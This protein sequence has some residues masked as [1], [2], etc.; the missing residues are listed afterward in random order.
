MKIIFAT[1]VLVALTFAE[2][3]NTNLTSSYEEFKEKFQKALVEVIKLEI[4]KYHAAH[5]NTKTFR[6]LVQSIERIRK[7]LALV[8]ECYK[9]GTYG[10]DYRGYIGYTKSGRVCQ[11][12]NSQS[13]HVHKYGPEI[14]P[15][16]GLVAN[17]C[18]IGGWTRGYKPWCYTMDEDKV[19]EY[20]NIPICLDMSEYGPT[21]LETWEKEIWELLNK[22]RQSLNE[23]QQ[24][25]DEDQQ[26][27]EED[28]DTT[29][30]DEFKQKFLKAMKETIQ[31]E[32]RKY[33]AANDNAAMENLTGSITQ[34]ENCLGLRGGLGLR[35]APEC[36][37][38]SK[39]LDYRGQK[40]VTK[41]GQ[42]CQYWNTNSPHEP[43]HKPA[44]GNAE[45]YCRNPSKAQEPWCYTTDENKK[46]EYCGIPKCSGAPEGRAKEKRQSINQDP[47]FCLNSAKW[48]MA[49]KGGGCYS[50]LYRG[51]HFPETDCQ[52]SS[53]CT[54][55][56]NCFMIAAYVN[57]VEA[58]VGL[59]W[60]VHGCAEPA[61]IDHI[62]DNDETC[63][64]FKEVASK[65]DPNGG[66]PPETTFN[67]CILHT[68]LRYVTDSPYS[69]F[70]EKIRETLGEIIQLEIRKK[71]AVRDDKK[72]MKNLKQS[73][74]FL[75]F[76]SNGGN[77]E[78]RLMSEGDVGTSM[79]GRRTSVGR[80]E[81][82]HRGEWGT[83]CDDG[84]WNST[85]GQNLAKVVCR[86]KG[87]ADGTAYK[88]PGF[89]A[90]TRRI[91][92]NNVACIGNETSLCD[93]PHNGWGSTENCEHHE[94]GI[95]CV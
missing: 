87:F 46:W 43:A 1:F 38:Q 33:Y 3:L 32:I 39:G 35:D 19:W 66:P 72:I 62:R 57:G 13:P 24:S 30:Y 34:L 47:D 5:D 20:C 48:N 80:L 18:R 27:L 21:E 95:T 69:E 14:Y 11:D 78:I 74:E 84:L 94:V 54:D 40:A 56:M 25:L 2:D 6:K 86:I 28:P 22:N 93:C 37:V 51:F 89:E 29:S 88:H 75:Q 17:F 76:Q 49:E 31:L 15:N 64:V 52:I 53:T 55:G 44:G 41:S 71:D 26:S 92:L 16:T 70:K 61:V 58:G 10:A 82:Y 4:G 81:I 91:W 36:Y 45:N 9:E 23:D 8:R 73:L 59:P 63:D 90:G 83:V 65:I 68:C 85:N 50:C 42:E 60:V 12:W 7:H 77:G 79:V 67:R